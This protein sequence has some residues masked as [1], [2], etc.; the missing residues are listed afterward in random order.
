MLW[1]AYPFTTAY[2]SSVTG[3]YILIT[4]TGFPLSF[5]VVVLLDKGINLT[6]YL[7]RTIEMIINDFI[8]TSF[9]SFLLIFGSIFN[10]L[11]VIKGSLFPVVDMNDIF[12]L[13]NLFLHSASFICDFYISTCCG[14]SDVLVDQLLHIINY[15][16][17]SW[18]NFCTPYLSDFCVNDSTISLAIH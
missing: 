14:N 4:Y 11:I 17:L 15:W 6:I 9:V 1:Y 12:I 2:F 3:S 10:N 13:D 18:D 5:F 7:R 16:C 8:C